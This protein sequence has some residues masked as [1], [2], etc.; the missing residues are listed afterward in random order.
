[1]KE[2]VGAIVAAAGRGERLGR[3]PK[4]LVSLA[5]RPLL[6]W[7]LLSLADCP[8]V[9]EIVIAAP[10]EEETAVRRLAGDFPQ[11]R[12][13]VPGGEHRQHSVARGLA[14]LS[15]EVR[16]VVVHDAARPL[17]TPG[18]VEAVIR[19][20]WEAG[21]ALAAV[22]VADTLKE[23]RERVTRTLSREGVWQAQTP[24]AF[25]RDWL[26]RAHR[27]A[28]R[29]GY[30]ATDDSA[31]LEKYGYPVRLVRGNRL[32]LKI[33]EPEDLA[34]AEAWLERSAPVR[35]GIGFDAHRLVEGRRLVLGGVEIPFPRGLEGHSD[36]DALCHAVMDALLGAAGERDIGHWFP[37]ADPRFRAARSLELLRQVADTLRRRGWVPVNVDLTV[38]AEAPLL[39]PYLPQMKINL[40]EALGLAPEAVGVKATTAEGM[41]ALGRGEG[42]AAWA[43]C[44]ARFPGRSGP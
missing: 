18:L 28:A 10:P 39:A 26:E 5:G 21:A 20:A 2:A 1:M 38:V 35:V 36:A 6:R 17:V 3:G 7:A 15:G 24:Q 32:N 9:S 8:L 40:A 37:P 13:V 27:Q 44:S 19:A 31:L 41:G 42:I 34:W 25:R 23:G 33:T 11:V 14:A 12:A 22:P 29:E 30:V 43:V 16:W 4:A